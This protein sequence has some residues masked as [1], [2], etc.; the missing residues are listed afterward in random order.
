MAVPGYSLFELYQIAKNAKQ[1]WNAFTDEFESA[2]ARVRELVETCDYLS[3]V[4]FDFT[5]LL[6]QCEE[7]YPQERSFDRKLL[8]CQTFIDRYLSLKAGYLTELQ[9]SGSRRTW[10]QV[11]YTALPLSLQSNTSAKN[12]GR[13]TARYACDDRRAQELRDG[14]SLEIQKLLA[15]TVVFALRKNAPVNCSPDLCNARDWTA[16]ASRP[17]LRLDTPSRLAIPQSRQE[18]EFITLR[19]QLAEF[20]TIFQDLVVIRYSYEREM[21]S[22]IQWARPANIEPLKQ[23]LE[24][25]WHRLYVRSGLIDRDSP[26]PPLPMEPRELLEAPARSYDQLVVNAAAPSMHEGL[27]ISTD[28]RQLTQLNNRT[29]PRNPSQSRPNPPSTYASSSASR[30][31]SSIS[32]VSLY[33]PSTPLTTPYLAAEQNAPTVADFLLPPSAISTELPPVATITLPILRGQTRLLSWNIKTVGESHFVEWS[34]ENGAEVLLHFLPH[35][36][37]PRIYHSKTQQRLDVTFD[38]HHQVT[39]VSGDTTIYNGPTIVEYVFASSDKR[40]LFQGDIRDM[41]HVKAFDVDVIWSNLHPS[42]RWGNLAGMARLEKLNLWQSSRFPY[43]H[44][45][46][47][48]ASATSGEQHEHKLLSFRNSP[49]YTQ[50]SKVVQLYLG[51]GGSGVSSPRSRRNSLVSRWSRRSSNLSNDT[52]YD[53][54]VSPTHQQPDSNDPVQPEYI[55]IQFTHR[56]EYDLFREEYERAHAEDERL[57]EPRYPNDIAELGDTQ[58][59]VEMG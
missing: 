28:D 2:P 26:T 54:P 1:I 4:L 7:T 8:E 12:H 38:E 48:F 6:E 22:A 51:W 29:R 46:S 17:Q 32:T 56:V 11:W 53:V 18:P 40:D 3:Q 25:V 31:T 10:M 24:S 14:L 57:P 58:A 35:P 16:A 5:S 43:H 39:L 50:R 49:Q 47:F 52:P 36:A 20:Q 21:T 44:S 13:Q 27:R 42:H 15:F 30:R 45:L 59:P 23:R 19:H 55:C 9:T 41:T 34:T 33:S 37:F